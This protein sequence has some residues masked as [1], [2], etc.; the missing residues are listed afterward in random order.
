MS[1]T[2][3]SGTMVQ[4][5]WSQGDNELDYLSLTPQV[6][7]KD[8]IAEITAML[9]LAEEQDVIDPGWYVGPV[10]PGET[11]MSRLIGDTMWAL[12][13]AGLTEEA[14]D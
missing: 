14:P 8:E 6:A 3:V 10:G 13:E 4:F 12:T 1:S 2:A 9:K 7:T 5:R 11:T